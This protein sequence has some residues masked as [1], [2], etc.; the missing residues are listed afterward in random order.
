MLLV[1]VSTDGDQITILS[2][3]LR[4]EAFQGRLS[5]NC[6]IV[7]KTSRA[8]KKCLAKTREERRREEGPHSKLTWP[9]LRTPPNELDLTALHLAL[10]WTSLLQRRLAHKHPCKR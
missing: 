7:G 4:G 1:G 2:Y 6:K 5:F 8:Y 10:F 9:I 3:L